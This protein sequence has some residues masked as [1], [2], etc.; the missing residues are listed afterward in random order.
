M[1]QIVVGALP[2]ASANIVMYGDNVAAMQHLLADEH[3]ARTVDLIY[4]DPPFCTGRVFYKQ[5][6]GT[7]YS[8]VFSSDAEYLRFL[9]D[10][11]RLLRQLMSDRGSLY[12]QI[13]RKYG[14]L[15]RRVIDRTI[16]RS[17]FRN[18]ITRIKCNP[19]NS[20]RKAYGNQT[21]TIYFF[22]L[23]DAIWNDCR[24]P[25]TK[26][27]LS[28]F[29]KVDAD[30]RRYTT[31][32]LHA[33]GTVSDGP[34]GGAW[35]GM[36]PPPGKHWA[37]T[38]DKLD[39]LDAAGLVEWSSTGNPRRKRYLDDV[40]GCWI[41]DVWQFKDKGGS[42]DDYPTE[43]N[44]AMLERII[45]QSSAPDSTVLDCFMGSGTTLVAAAKHGRR[46]I[47]I[48]E[49]GGS[50][51]ATVGRLSRETSSAFTI[52][53]QRPIVVNQPFDSA[54]VDADGIVRLANDLGRPQ[55]EAMLAGVPAPDSTWRVRALKVRSGAWSG[56]RQ[57]DTHVIAVDGQGNF[58]AHTLTSDAPAT[59]PALK[60][61]A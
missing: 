60:N 5:S 13:D 11:L 14:Y 37:T 6:G 45:L 7:G 39:Q 40:Q 57:S 34:T 28:Q 9:H 54:I 29:T 2:H 32:P 47:G 20:K 26:K 61:A 1:P 56:V 41:Q 31:S 23:P 19:K 49:S 43:K 18:E 10:R 8:D 53:A 33:P 55:P 12:L 30:G 4:I 22:S 46:F 42:R 51:A 35:R 21:D 50:L 52:S 59:V 48:D 38:P 25:V 24:E 44:L 36:L 16:G 3:L 58:A 27:Q 17:H 15:A